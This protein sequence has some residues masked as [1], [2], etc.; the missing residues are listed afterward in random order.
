ML[1]I[2]GKIRWVQFQ[3]FARRKK[4]TVSC[5]KSEA[6]P[7]YVSGECS[8]LVVLKFHVPENHLKGLWKSTALPPLLIK[9]FRFK[10]TY[11]LT[12]FSLFLIY[13]EFLGTAN[14]VYQQVFNKELGFMLDNQGILEISQEYPEVMYLNT[15]MIYHPC[16]TIIWCKK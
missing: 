6:L 13:T 7:G 12:T 9:N 8:S 16:Y 15:L 1:A 3:V 2:V 4:L 14:Q 5:Q 11:P 10:G